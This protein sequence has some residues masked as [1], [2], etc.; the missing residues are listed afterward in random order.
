VHCR[1]FAWR[2]AWRLQDP[3]LQATS[4]KVLTWSRAPQLLL[5]THHW[6]RKEPELLGECG[7]LC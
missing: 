1:W 5:A 2:F 4:E 6:L 7:L 3:D